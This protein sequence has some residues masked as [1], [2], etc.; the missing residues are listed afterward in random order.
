L[1][2]LE[3]KP[4]TTG[5]IV[6][7]ALELT[8]SGDDFKLVVRKGQA[9]KAKAALP[10]P[11]NVV[12]FPTARPKDERSDQAADLVRHFHRVFHGSEESYPSGKAIDQAAGLLARCGM[13]KARH[14]IDFAHREAARTQFKVA[15]FGAVMQ[16][17]A[18]AVK[19]FEDQEHAKRR[20]LEQRRAE[21]AKKE[22]EAA[23]ERAQEAAFQG[24]FESLSKEERKRFEAEAIEH[25]PSYGLG[26]LLSRYRHQENP[27]GRT[28]QA[29]LK[30][31]LRA[32]FEATQPRPS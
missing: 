7:I 10:E 8:K 17:E 12:P 20:Q 21:G 26:S 32:H 19:D 22:G 28:A 3:G 9:S 25:A 15:A 31:L 1:R 24:Y 14:I 23:Q 18:R 30:R 16:Y 27:E 13:K 29:Y 2:E 11:S 6:K 5:S 4:V